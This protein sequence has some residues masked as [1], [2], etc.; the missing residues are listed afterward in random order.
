M[1]IVICW[2]QMKL[3]LLVVVVVKKV[4]VLFKRMSFVLKKYSVKSF[5][6]SWK[7]YMFIWN[8]LFWVGKSI[9]F[10]LEMFNRQSKKLYPWLKGCHQWFKSLP[11]EKFHLVK[12]FHVQLKRSPLSWKKYFI[13]LLVYQTNPAEVN[14]FLI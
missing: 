9:F 6:F 8:Q 12:K 10:C 3:L 1:L 14:S 13:Y 2:V 11:L 7:G 5:T 4:H